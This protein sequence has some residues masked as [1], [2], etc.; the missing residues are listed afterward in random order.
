MA[1]AFNDDGEEINKDKKTEWMVSAKKSLNDGEYIMNP[2]RLG[3]CRSI[4]V[5]SLVILFI[6][7]VRKRVKIK[8]IAVE[9]ASPMTLITNIDPHYV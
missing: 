1:L 4:R 5:V 2:V 9:K 7:K 6:N 8:E 3:L